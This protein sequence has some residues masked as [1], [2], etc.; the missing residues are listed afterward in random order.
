MIRLEDLN[1]RVR[2]G[3][4]SDASAPEYLRNLTREDLACL[5]APRPT[6]Q[7]LAIKRIRDSHHVLARM[8]AEGRP[9]TEICALTGYDASRLSILRTDPSFQELIAY[10]RQVDSIEYATSHARMNLL[11]MDTLQEMHDRLLEA[12]DKIDLGELHQQFKLLADRT[13]DGPQSKSTNL[14]IHTGFAERLEQAR[15]RAADRALEAPKVCNASALV[16]EAAE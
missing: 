9:G 3:R 1:L 12:P 13:G 15:Q 10:Y 11:K 4:R 8:C 5:N 2:G 6:A 14:H 7:P 16:T